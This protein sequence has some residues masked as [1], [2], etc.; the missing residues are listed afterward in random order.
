MLGWRRSQVDSLILRVDR[1][2]L[3]DARL[4]VGRK[5]AQ[6]PIGQS[7]GHRDVKESFRQGKVG[8][9]KLVVHGAQLGVGRHSIRQ[10]RQLGVREVVTARAACVDG[11]Q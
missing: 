6:D 10:G 9:S 5:T 3:R 4:A 2:F 11:F 1:L 8:F 7:F